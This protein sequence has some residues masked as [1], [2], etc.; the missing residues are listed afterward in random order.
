[1]SL[2][3]VMAIKRMT[4]HYR[5]V[6]VSLKSG[7]HQG[8]TKRMVLKLNATNTYI[9]SVSVL[10]LER[11]ISIHEAWVYFDPPEKYKYNVLPI[12]VI[13]QRLDLVGQILQ[14]II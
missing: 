14:V 5:H 11:S 7:I 13:E 4:S 3:P 12:S 6:N 9:E 2:I 10:N 8:T 1:M